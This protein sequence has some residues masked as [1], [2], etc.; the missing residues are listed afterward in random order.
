MKP[1]LEKF[2]KFKQ[3]GINSLSSSLHHSECSFFFSTI[4]PSVM[5]IQ[6]CTGNLEEEMIKM[7]ARRLYKQHGA[8]ETGGYAR[9]RGG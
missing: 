1:E 8:L 6:Y 2:Y 5:L 9:D 4:S 7:S 3:E